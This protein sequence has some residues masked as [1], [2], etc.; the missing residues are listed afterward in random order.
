MPETTETTR[1]NRSPNEVFALLSDFSRLAEWDPMFES[2]RRLDSGELGVGSRFHVVGS[3]M[4]SEVELELEVVEYQPPHRI[5]LNGT[6]DGLQ[7]TEDL[8]V[9]AVEEG[10]EVTY[11][12]AF[13]TDKP[14]VLDAATKPGFVLVGK[15]A[16][17][18][19]DDWIID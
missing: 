11:H 12:S 19:M 3:I 7:T 14:D 5:V 16:M 2:S 9:S 15:S 13:E 8:T 17:R 10:A 6:G 18:G 1:F 4:G